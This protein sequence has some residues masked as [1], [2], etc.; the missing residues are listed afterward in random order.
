MIKVS[1]SQPSSQSFLSRPELTIQIRTKSRVTVSYQN[2]TNTSDKTQILSPSPLTGQP[3]CEDATHCC[4]RRFCQM[5]PS[6]L[7]VEAGG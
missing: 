6:A 7:A 2:T 3:G 5:P 1:L 4:P